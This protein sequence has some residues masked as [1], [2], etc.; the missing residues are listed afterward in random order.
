VSMKAQSEQIDVRD[1]RRRERKNHCWRRLARNCGSLIREHWQ[2]QQNIPVESC[3]SDLQLT[4]SGIG[5]LVS[6]FRTGVDEARWKSETSEAH[7]EV[8]TC[9]RYQALYVFD[10]YDGQRPRRSQLRRFPNCQCKSL[11]QDSTDVLVAL[12]QLLPDQ[13]PA[14]ACNLLQSDSF[15]LTSTRPSRNHLSD[16]GFHAHGRFLLC[17]FWIPEFSRLIDGDFW[18]LAADRFD[19]ELVHEGADEKNSRGPDTFR[20]FSFLSGSGICSGSKPFPWSRMRIS[21]RSQ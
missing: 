12:A 18:S 14:I 11:R 16:C 6:G 21:S 8:H 19:P 7:E 15:P 13:P 3:R 9:Y 1:G 2:G 10:I 17:L 5:E 20:G 4:V